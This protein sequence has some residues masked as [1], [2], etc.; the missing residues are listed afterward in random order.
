MIGILEKFLIHLSSVVDLDNVSLNWMGAVF[1]PFTDLLGNYFWVIFWTAI[2][3]GVYIKTEG[4]ALPSVILI[5][6]TVFVGATLET[7][8]VYLYAILA[9]AGI[10]T[11]V[12]RLYTRRI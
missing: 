12:Y 7:E 2:A 11:V 1:E 8:V 6:S 9:A 3:G 5:L 4:V 10:A